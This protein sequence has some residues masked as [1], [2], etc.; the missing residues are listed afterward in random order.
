MSKRKSA[1]KTIY[2]LAVI[3]LIIEI[4][5]SV[6]F[7]ALACLTVMSAA[8]S[9]YEPAA[10]VFGIVVLV[11]FLICSVVS[12][13]FIRSYCELVEDTRRSR[14]ALELI[15]SKLKSNN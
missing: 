10:V 11:I 5:A 1:G 15:T 14:E 8:E 12:F 3:V 7:S 9:Q 2:A 4:I 6:F 13:V